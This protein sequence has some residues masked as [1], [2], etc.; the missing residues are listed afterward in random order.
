MMSETKKTAEDFRPLR[1]RRARVAGFTLIEL[2]VVIAIIAILAS[3]LLPALARAKAK[4]K[5]IQCVSNLKQLGLAQAMYATDFGKS[6]L[7]EPNNIWMGTLISYYA[8][9]NAV[10]LCPLASTPTTRTD[11]SLT[12]TYGTGN[13]AW[14]WSPYGTVY[15]GSYGLNGWLYSSYVEGTP[16][17]LLGTPASWQYTSEASIIS[18]TTTP[19]FGDAIWVDGWA[20][21]TEGPAKNLYMGNAN[22]DMGRYTLAR[23]GSVDPLAAPQNLTTSVGLPGSVNM[24]FYDGH[25]TPEKLQNFWTLDWHANW[26]IPGTIPAPQ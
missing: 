4:A 10:R 11:Y 25:A 20:Y 7:Y 18:P 26:T 21:E 23:H 17:D 19:L 22:K 16:S 14:N 15:Q 8:Q 13:M 1:S 12:Y 5:D 6:F 24:A 3:L 2:L 9:A